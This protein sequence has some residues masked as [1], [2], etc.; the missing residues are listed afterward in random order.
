MSKQQKNAKQTK[1]QSYFPLYIA[2]AVALVALVTMI[3]VL[4]LPKRDNIVKG[5]FVPPAFDSAAVEGTPEV[6]DGLG[7]MECYRDG[8]DFRFH[9]CGKVIMEGKNANVYLTNAESNDVWLKVRVLDSEGNILGESGLIKPGE[10]IQSVELSEQLAVGTPV[11]LKVM[12]YEPETYYSAGAV[13]LNTQI[14][15]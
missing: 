8:M 7:Y 11:K 4:C 2:G 9:A 1:K 10:Y 14:G 5:E 12:A 15:G 13:D 3:V 6:P